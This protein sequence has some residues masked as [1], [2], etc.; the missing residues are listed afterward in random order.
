MSFV[1]PQFIVILIVPQQVIALG[2]NRFVAENKTDVFN[3]PRHLG[4]MFDIS[5]VSF[6]CYP[7]KHDAFPRSLS[8][9]PISCGTFSVLAFPPVI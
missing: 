2:V 9:G 7:D 3:E 6:F 4:V 1:P 5:L 8:S